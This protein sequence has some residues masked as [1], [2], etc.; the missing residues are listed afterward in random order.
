MASLGDQIRL[1][2]AQQELNRPSG[3]EW[4]QRMD[5]QRM[6]SESSRQ[7]Q[8]MAMAL[9]Y[10]KHEWQRHMDMVGVEAEYAAAMGQENKAP[11]DP[12]LTQ[13]HKAATTKGQYTYGKA[14]AKTA[15]D[16]R[17]MMWDMMEAQRKSDQWGAEQKVR[18]DR[19]GETGRHNVKMEE[20]AMLR[21]G[22][23]SGLATNMKAKEMLFATRS[24]INMYDKK[25]QEASD[26]NKIQAGLF[27]QK[28]AQRLKKERDD[29][30]LGYRR[31]LQALGVETVPGLSE[32]LGGGE[33]QVA[34]T[35]GGV[36]AEEREALRGEVFGAD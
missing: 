7:N 9:E 2:R 22:G 3:E 27:S 18:T 35:T 13:T 12:R 36:T 14:Q 4:R 20:A 1:Y 24:L 8:A 6:E 5:L 17:K 33:G 19:I 34:G 16:Q 21:A 30:V 32:V 25:I 11:T 10:K 28:D 23:L 15:A 31:Q 29:L 26:I